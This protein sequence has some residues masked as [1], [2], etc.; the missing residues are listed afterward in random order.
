MQQSFCE[1]QTDG[2]GAVITGF[3]Q[4]SSG[5]EKDLQTAV[6]YVGPISVAVDGSSTA[7]RVRNISII[8]KHALILSHIVRYLGTM[9]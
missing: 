2:C 7:F 5:S 9:F 3:V 4:V 6:A 1:Y 8:C